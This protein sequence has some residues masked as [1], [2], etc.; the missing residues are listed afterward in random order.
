MAPCDSLDVQGG[1]CEIH[2][3]STPAHTSTPWTYLT[4]TPLDEAILHDPSNIRASC[5]PQ[6]A[7]EDIFTAGKSSIAALLLRLYEPAAGQILLDGVPL[8][9]LEP[10]WLRRIIGSV[11]QEPAL[12]SGTVR[13]IIS[14]ADPDASQARSSY[15]TRP[16]KCKKFA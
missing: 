15:C 6:L 10:S 7:H 2:S 3:G 12:L 13:E 11:S 9:A 5:R 14:Y 16:R 4:F 8:D 1:N